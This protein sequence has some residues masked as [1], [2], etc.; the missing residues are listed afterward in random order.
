MTDEH[1]EDAIVD[2]MA[3]SKTTKVVRKRAAKG[4]PS[5]SPRQRNFQQAP[6][7][8]LPRAGEHSDDPTFGDPSWVVRQLQTIPEV[9]PIVRKLV[10][11]T[12][13]T[14]EEGRKRMAGS[15]IFPAIGFVASKE[16]RM[17]VF[18]KEHGA[19]DLWARSGFDA[20]FS[21]GRLD[22]T[23]YRPSF[24]SFYGRL[25]ELE[26]E[27]YLAA[28]EEAGDELIQL[29]RRHDGRIG[30]DVIV[31]GTAF[32]SP[33]RLHHA[34]ED[35]AGCANAPGRPRQ[36]LAEATMKEIKKAHWDEQDDA[37]LTPHELRKLRGRILAKE[38]R[39]T[40]RAIGG[41][42]YKCLDPDAGAC[43]YDNGTSW[44]GGKDM[45][46]VD[47]FT[48]G[49]LANVHIVAGTPEYRA[50]PALHRKTTRATGA[51][52]ETVSGDKG[53]AEQ[54]VFRLAAR[55]RVAINLPFRKPNQSITD[56]AQLRT[57]RYDEYGTPRCVHCGGP[58][59]IDGPRL[60]LH[61]DKG[62]PV[63]RFR[64]LLGHTDECKI[65]VQQRRCDENWQLLVGLA[66]TSE[67][68][69][70]L[71][72]IEGNYERTFR[73]ARTRFG[74]SGKDTSMRLPRAGIRAQRLR[75]AIGRLIEWFYICLRHGWIGNHPY[76]N[77]ESVL[78]RVGLAY[79]RYQKAVRRKKGLDLPYGPK[80]VTLG[81]APPP[82]PEPPPEPSAP[83][84]PPDAPP[85]GA[86]GDDDIPF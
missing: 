39:Y 1:Y 11:R 8:Y 72:T 10:E 28:V 77:T 42:L 31:D 45:A 61:I 20:D 5:T 9:Q 76:R 85:L 34:C 84:P 3:K 62:V 57:D 73:E 43:T 14:N 47:I 35:E 75:A 80:A 74:R 50:Y 29:A 41:H 67:R 2:P 4:T 38:G 12:T 55:R 32:L 46:A 83:D 63:L 56:R 40:I 16:T 18:W 53:L 81:L 17:E 23:E 25:T 64:C 69:A 21:G 24:G 30:R 68:R 37:P 70:A 33:S 22:G 26:Q 78:H 48:G 7:E 58:G 27:Q 71:M 54:R 52:M 79:H 60:G 13:I 59:Y 82:E 15:W 6:V 19:S 49:T 86:D 66:R 44:V 65:R 51:E 36:T